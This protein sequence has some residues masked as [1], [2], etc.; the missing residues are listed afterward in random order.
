MNTK[1][2]KK[3]IIYKKKLKKLIKLNLLIQQKKMLELIEIIKKKLI[4]VK[5]VKKFNR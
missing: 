2:V 1:N 3:K 5:K 4:N